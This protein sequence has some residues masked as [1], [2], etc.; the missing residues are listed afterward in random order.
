MTGHAGDHQPLLAARGEFSTCGA[1]Q[2]IMQ[3]SGASA[4]AVGLQGQ[5][6]LL[7]VV[8]FAHGIERHIVPHTWDMKV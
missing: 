8:R 2:S 6:C 1:G 7:P 3:I 4:C 5:E